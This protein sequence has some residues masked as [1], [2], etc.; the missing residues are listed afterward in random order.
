MQNH[1]RKTETKHVQNG[2]GENDVKH[3]ENELIKWKGNDDDGYDVVVVVLV[4]KDLLRQGDDDGNDGPK[5]QLLH[6]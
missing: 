1:P 5:V 4:D 3:G 6:H 2:K